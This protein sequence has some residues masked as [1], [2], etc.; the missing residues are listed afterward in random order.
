VGAQGDDKQSWVELPFWRLVKYYVCAFI[1][2][3]ISFSIG[4]ISILCIY[5]PPLIPFLSSV[6]TMALIAYWYL[7]V[8]FLSMLLLALYVNFKPKKKKVLEVNTKQ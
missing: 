4:T 2:G 8:F 6:I 3:G 7:A 1:V 5:F